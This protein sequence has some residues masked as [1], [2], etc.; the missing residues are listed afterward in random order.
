[1]LM[2][3]ACGTEVADVVF[4]AEARQVQLSSL[5]AVAVDD[6]TPKIDPACVLIFSRRLFRLRDAAE[7]AVL[8]PVALAF[9][10]HEGNATVF[11]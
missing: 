8:E 5:A 11:S 6:A 4:V 1:M 7:V 3:R 9:E 2:R 10:S